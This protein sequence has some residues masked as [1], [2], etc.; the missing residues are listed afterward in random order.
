MMKSI[1]LFVAISFFL[2]RD[3]VGFDLTIEFSGVQHQKNGQIVVALYRAKDHFPDRDSRYK[4]IIIPH[5]HFTATFTNLP[6]DQYAVAAYFDENKNLFLDKN[7]VGYP[8][9]KYGFSNNARSKFSAPSFDMASI[10]LNNDKKIVIH[11]Y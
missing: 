1:V 7:M 10:E 8:T 11:L 2:H 6:K 4:Y 5:K 3:R 9:E